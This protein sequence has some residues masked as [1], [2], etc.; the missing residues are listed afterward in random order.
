VNAAACLLSVVIW[1]AFG[2]A[3][4]R[5]LRYPRARIAFNA[6]MA[7]LLVVSLVPVFW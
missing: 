6:V 1:A 5:F 2:T 3:I 7:S 4:G